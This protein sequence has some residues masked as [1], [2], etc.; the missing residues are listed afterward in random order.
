[1]P[2]EKLYQTVLNAI[3]E[4]RG[5]LLSKTP[6]GVSLQGTVEDL[7]GARAEIESLTRVAL[8]TTAWPTPSL[9]LPRD[10]LA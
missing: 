9:E 4:R 8:R 2:T 6:E 1:M 10:L 3:A 5:L 7:Q